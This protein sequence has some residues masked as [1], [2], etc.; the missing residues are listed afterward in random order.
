MI[1]HILRLPRGKMSDRSYR[2]GRYLACMADLY[3]HVGIDDISHV[4]TPTGSRLMIAWSLRIPA[5]SILP[6]AAAAAAVH[7]TLLLPPLSTTAATAATAIAIATAA[8]GCCS[9]LLRLRLS[10]NDQQPTQVAC[11]RIALPLSLPV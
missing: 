10:K 2:S 5:I 1:M 6:Y 7:A 8:L 11:C 9:W 3:H 4:C